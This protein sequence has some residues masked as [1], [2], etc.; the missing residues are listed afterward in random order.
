MA[1]PLRHQNPGDKFQPSAA[2]WN[3]FVDTARIVGDARSIFRP[4]PLLPDTSNSATDDTTGGGSGGGGCSCCD[5]TQCLDMCNQ[6]P[7]SV[8][9][10]SCAA[11]GP[12]PKR[13]TANFGT[14][15]GEQTFTHT[16]GCVW[17]T[18]DFDVTYTYPGPG[19]TDTGVY[20]A[21][22]T[23]TA[24]AETCVVTYV[25]GTDCLK[26]STTRT[27]SWKADPDREWS[28][29]CNSVMIP[30]VNPAKFPPKIYTMCELCI[31]PVDDAADGADWTACHV[32]A[33]CVTSLTLPDFDSVNRSDPNS[34]AA[35]W[36]ANIAKSIA[37]SFP[38]CFTTLTNGGTETACSLDDSG[39]CWNEIINNFPS[40]SF[41]WSGKVCV[42]SDGMGG[43]TLNLTLTVGS[44]ATSPLESVVGTGY[45]SISVASLVVGVNTLTKT[46][47]TGSLT[48]PDTYDLSV[49]DCTFSTG[50]YDYGY[51]CGNGADGTGGGHTCSGAC[52]WRAQDKDGVIGGLGGAPFT[53]HSLRPEYDVFC[54]DGCSCASPP[55]D[56]TSSHDTYPVACT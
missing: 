52:I 17:E 26:L 24:G 8:I 42:A 6:K 9:S 27:L 41:W 15:L 7:G 14:L 47:S 55:T 13:Y 34:V 11:C 46:S 29:T 35:N 19:G 28:C 10:S 21:T 12:S 39:G 3:A 5:C 33:G 30:S 54:S 43:Y 49:D 45:Y 38:C 2:T 37:I 44:G 50:S 53:W 32:T 48:W 31:A 18:D 25:S 1:P 22:L 40:A 20:K 23:L 56:P 4:G 51:G 16:T 36:S